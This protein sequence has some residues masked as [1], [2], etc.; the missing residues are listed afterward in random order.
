MRRMLAISCQNTSFNEGLQMWP[1]NAIP[2]LLLGFQH[3]VIRPSFQKNV[4]ILVTTLN[5]Q[6]FDPIYHAL[7]AIP[8]CSTPHASWVLQTPPHR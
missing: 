8:W 7:R 6:C 2:N 5:E 4:N 3:G 1:F